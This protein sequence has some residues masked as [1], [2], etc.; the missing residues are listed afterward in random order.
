MVEIKQ[1]RT[2]VHVEVA[3]EHYYFGSLTAVYTMFTPEQLGVALGT[4]RNYR[5]TSDKPY[6]NN[7]CIIRKGT[8]TTMPKK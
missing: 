1:E 3:G 2:V 6:T 5:V 7:K 4:L 8:L